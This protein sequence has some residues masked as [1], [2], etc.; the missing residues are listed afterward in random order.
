MRSGRKGLSPRRDIA[1]LNNERGEALTFA[2]DR[3]RAI[4]HCRAGEAA[5]SDEF[6]GARDGIETP[7]LF[8]TT[9]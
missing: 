6:A 3:G 9:K 5:C 1:V 2:E 7:S 8:R 4:R